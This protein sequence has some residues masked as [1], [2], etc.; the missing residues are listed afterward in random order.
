M[1]PIL[2]LTATLLT[3]CAHA[4]VFEPSEDQCRAD[5]CYV[6]V[7]DA[8]IEQCRGCP[9]QSQPVSRLDNLVIDQAFA[10]MRPEEPETMTIAYEAPIELLRAVPALTSASSSS[11]AF[12]FTCGTGALRIEASTGQK[13]N[14]ITVWNAACTAGT[15]TT[16]STP[17]FLGGDYSPTTGAQV[18]AVTNATGMPICNT[19]GC[20]GILA[21]YEVKNLECIAASTV[22][23]TAAVVK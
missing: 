22:I 4:P 2:L 23:V 7:N 5:G 3:A 15:C 12:Q 6:D 21:T 14:T 10:D 16:S 11:P 19:A 13:Y 8:N 9:A 20:A 18:T 1:R 17:V